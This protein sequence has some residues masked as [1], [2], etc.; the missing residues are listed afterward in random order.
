M[1]G[2]TDAEVV[3]HIPLRAVDFHILLVLS[4]QDLH[5][6][7]IVKEIAAE[8]EGRLT[9]E[10]GN[11]YRYLRRLVDSGLVEAAE[12]RPVEDRGEERRRYYK[13]TPFGRRVLAA[14]ALRMH[15]LAAVASA[16]VDL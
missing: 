11:L 13:V 2:R 14:E 12:R 10:P 8:S 1:A 5:G 16:R 7:G 4:H 15:R 6:Y 3:E 9:L